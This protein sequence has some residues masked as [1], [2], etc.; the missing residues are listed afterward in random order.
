[1]SPTADASTATVAPS[2]KPTRY[3]LLVNI[4][5]ADGLE[6]SRGK[7]FYCKLYVGEMSVAVAKASGHAS[8]SAKSDAKLRACHSKV[9]RSARRT[10]A[11]WDETLELALNDPQ[12]ELLSIR[13]KNQLPVYCPCIGACSID[14][15]RLRLGDDP[16]TLQTFALRADGEPA[17]SIELRL[18]LVRNVRRDPSTIEVKSAK[19]RQKMWIGSAVRASDATPPQP[20]STT[21]QQS[22]F[23]QYSTLEEAGVRQRSVPSLRSD[24]HTR[25]PTDSRPVRSREQ[26]EQEQIDLEEERREAEVLRNMR[27]DRLAQR[28]ITVTEISVAEP[29]APARSQPRRLP[30]PPPQPQQQRPEQH[31]PRLQRQ[32]QP[33]PSEN[34]IQHHLYLPIAHDAGDRR[35]PVIAP[36]PTS[37]VGSSASDASAHT[38]LSRPHS[39]SFNVATFERKNV[40]ITSKDRNLPP[41]SAAA[42]AST[43]KDP[44]RLCQSMPA[45]PRSNSSRLSA[46][47][48]SLDG[49]SFSSQFSYVPG[50]TQASLSDGSLG[51]EDAW[52]FDSSPP[53]HDARKQPRERPDA[54][55]PQQ[56]HHLRSNS[57]SHSHPQRLRLHQRDNQIEDDD[58]YSF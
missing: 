12:K 21:L 17:G 40:A 56:L 23:T 52:V 42:S 38:R 25:R 30:P 16:P 49:S 11:S 5:T 45:R 54:R 53:T 57:T 32:H 15:S 22:A 44:T 37:P 46:T 24:V 27:R 1:M 14:L 35:P 39:N 33:Q 58:A 47:S 20:T 19:E 3:T 43:A 28:G 36:T 9:T 34:H 51:P 8:S 7:S 6:H 18:H 55:R 10:S 48:R 2:P 29:P 13:V 31:Q 41:P 26:R 4:H 50:S